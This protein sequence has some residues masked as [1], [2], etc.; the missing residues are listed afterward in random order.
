MSTGFDDRKLG[1]FRGVPGSFLPRAAHMSSMQP[2]TS[3]RCEPLSSEISTVEEIHLEHGVV[4]SNHRGPIVDAL[5][6]VRQRLNGAGSDAWTVMDVNE[7]DDGEDFIE[8]HSGLEVVCQLPDPAACSDR[9][10]LRA[11]AE[12]IANAPSDL[13]A[14]LDAL[15]AG[16]ELADRAAALC[17]PGEEPVSGNMADAAVADWGRSF[18]A[19]VEGQ[20]GGVA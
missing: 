12:F 3:T 7:P 6:R 9:E 18:R 5:E 20:L 10:E 17:L 19:T 1:P 14:L 2:T 4:I 13:E 16:L 11:V 15:D 8:V